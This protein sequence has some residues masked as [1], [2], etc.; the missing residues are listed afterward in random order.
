MIKKK[1]VVNYVN[2]R[3]FC[4]ALKEYKNK[5]NAAKELGKERPRVPEY[6]GECL[7]K[8]SKGLARKPNFSGYSYI[9]DMQFDAIENCLK[10]IDNFDPHRINPE[11]PEKLAN[12]FA[13]FTQIMHFAFLRRMEKEKKQHYA[14]IM[15]LQNLLIET[16]LNGEHLNRKDFEMFDNEITSTFV[17]NFEANVEKK[18]TKKVENAAANTTDNF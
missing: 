15:G 14:K 2:N 3:D 8:I 17:K 9:E 16:D 6:V 10:Y 7:M 1:R 18:K 5:V 12:P 13:Y 4:N 11:F